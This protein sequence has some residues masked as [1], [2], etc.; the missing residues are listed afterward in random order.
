MKINIKV[1]KNT[2]WW[3]DV[4]IQKDNIFSHP[5]A[6]YAGCLSFALTTASPGP[7]TSVQ[8]QKSDPL[9]SR[10]QVD[11]E[12]AHFLVTQAFEEDEKGND[13]EAIELYTQAVEL[14]I[15][16]VVCSLFLYRSLL[17]PSLSSPSVIATN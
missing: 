6:P 2:N 12:R 17:F 10:Q 16:T 11:L 4:S 3:R 9:K 5:D 8:A 7:L 1:T 14:C 13:D 15:K